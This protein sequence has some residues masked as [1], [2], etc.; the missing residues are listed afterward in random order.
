MCPT[1]CLQAKE[2][3][4]AIRFSDLCSVNYKASAIADAVLYMKKHSIMI[5]VI[6][7]AQSGY[8]L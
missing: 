4:A 5:L 6:F 7:L 3:L 8:S 2:Q 1:L